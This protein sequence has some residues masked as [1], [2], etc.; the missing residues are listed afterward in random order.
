MSRFKDAYD[1]TMCS[2]CNSSFQT[3]KTPPKIHTRFAQKMKDPNFK[4]D[5][6][7]LN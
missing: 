5:V 7:I 2:V 3:L 4:P 6:E 1:V